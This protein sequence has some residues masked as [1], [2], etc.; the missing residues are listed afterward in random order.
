MRRLVMGMLVLAC[1]SLVT[2]AS[3]EIATIDVWGSAPTPPLQPNVPWIDDL[4][5]DKF[6]PAWGELLS[7]HV[8]I[9]G[10]VYGEMGF[11]HTNPNGPTS[12]FDIFLGAEVQV[13]APPGA[14]PNFDVVLG[15][16]EHEDDIAAYDGIMNFDGPSGTSWLVS[17]SNSTGEI[18]VD[19]SN[20]APYIGPGQLF[21]PSQSIGR[22]TFSTSA[23]NYEQLMKCYAKAKVHIAYDYRVIPEM[24]TLALASLGGFVWLPLFRRFR[25]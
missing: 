17:E 22:S 8:W 12:F 2:A 19:P 1:M 15:R 11:E 14:G 13:T 3:A 20:F 25:K 4:K 10:Q 24:N 7:V 6:N 18:V 23:V 9:S 16:H 21:L 5:I